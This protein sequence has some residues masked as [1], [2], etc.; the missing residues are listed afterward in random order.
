MRFP[1]E[2]D[3]DAVPVDELRRYARQECKQ[4]SQREV[5]AEMGVGRTTLRNFVTEETNPHPRVRNLLHKWYR[6]RALRDGG[7]ASAALAVLLDG[8]PAEIVVVACGR[9]LDTVEWAH[10]EAG[11][12]PPAWLANARAVGAAGGEYDA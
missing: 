2:D 1:W 10:H 4:R 12:E 11:R 5:A 8:L 9:L 7:T 3:P 6:A